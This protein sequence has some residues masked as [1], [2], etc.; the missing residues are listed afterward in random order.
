MVD[1]DELLIFGDCENKGINHLIE[2]MERQN[3]NYLQALWVEMYSD[4]E[5]R[6]TQAHQD[7][8]SLLSICPYFDRSASRLST[9]ER[10]FGWRTEFDKAPIVFYTRQTIIDCGFHRIEGDARP[11]SQKGVVMHFLYLSDFI[12]KVDRESNRGVYFMNGAKYKCYKDRLDQDEG[13]SLFGEISEKYVN[14][15][16]FKSLGFF[17]A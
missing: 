13:L 11:Y 4:K 7:A 3:S 5:I 15:S 17:E 9:S 6:S 2:K 12:E 14:S 10:V 1:A 8:P 16:S